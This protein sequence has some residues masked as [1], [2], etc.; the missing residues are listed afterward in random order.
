MTENMG[1]WPSAHRKTATIR[2][3]DGCGDHFLS[4]NRVRGYD[5]HKL[6]GYLGNVGIIDW[7]SVQVTPGPPY[8][9]MS[10]S[11]TDRGA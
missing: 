9:S 2:S 1:K 8:F 4:S 7:S 6:G 10:Y 11:G 5:S 3:S